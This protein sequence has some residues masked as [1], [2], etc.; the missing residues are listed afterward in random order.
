M[1][2]WEGGREMGEQGRDENT[3]R[4]PYYG[5]MAEKRQEDYTSVSY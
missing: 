1:F 2:V 5:I 3:R 4:L